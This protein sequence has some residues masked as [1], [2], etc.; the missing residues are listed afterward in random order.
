MANVQITEG[1]ARPI[2]WIDQFR[3]LSTVAS[4][5]D[6]G[7]VTVS[8]LDKRLEEFRAETERL[9]NSIF[10]HYIGMRII[11][12]ARGSIGSCTLC[13]DENKKGYR[14]R[15][16]NVGVCLGCFPQGMAKRVSEREQFIVYTCPICTQCFAELSLA[17]PDPS[18]ST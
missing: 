7:F 4:P 15:N 11:R 12:S 17:S 3:P 13:H 1:R 9:D 8:A 14:C 16:C 6:E 10:S 5:F 18:L 2:S